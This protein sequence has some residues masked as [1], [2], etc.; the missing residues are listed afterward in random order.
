MANKVVLYVQEKISGLLQRV[1]SLG[2][3][4]FEALHVFPPI[5]PLFIFISSTLVTSGSE[6]TKRW[7]SQCQTQCFGA[8][9]HK[10]MSGITVSPLLIQSIVIP[11]HRLSGVQSTHI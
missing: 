5:T 7:Q 8:V 3:V 9:A 6:I 4:V 2:S 1:A 11:H 10:P